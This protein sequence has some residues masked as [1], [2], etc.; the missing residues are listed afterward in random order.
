MW[1][2]AQAERRSHLR[3]PS[4]DDFRR[5]AHQGGRRLIPRHQH[6]NPYTPEDFRFTT[7]GDVLYAIEL[8]WPN[9]P[10]A[11]IHSVGTGA[12]GERAVESVELLGSKT[13][14]SFQTKIDGLHIPLPE[15]APGKYAYTFRIRFTGGK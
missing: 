11:V 15:Q 1:V 9:K 13:K 2:L 5:R 10:E 8:A 14:V 12:V 3:H 6:A 4:L 7:K